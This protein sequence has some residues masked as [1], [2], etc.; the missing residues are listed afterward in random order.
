MNL[1]HDLFLL[2]F[3]LS[4]LGSEKNIIDLYIE[5][6]NDI[7]SPSKFEF[8]E[9]S[10]DDD[11]TLPLST[12][13]SFFGYIKISGNKNL[14][15]EK[16]SLIANTSFMVGSLLH[17]L[18]L[19]HTLEIKLEE[20][21][22][23]YEEK[24]IK[25]RTT[26][27]DLQNSRIAS[28]NLI[29]DLTDQID[30]R[31]EKERELRDSKEKFQTI[32]NETPVV[33]FYFNR[34]SI[35]TELNPAMEGIFGLKKSK[36]IGLNLR[37]VITDER[38][39]KVLSDTFT[40]GSGY[41]EGEYHSVISK[42]TSY[43]KAIGKGIK[44]NKGKIIAGL[45]LVEDISLK[46]RDELLLAEQQKML[47]SILEGTNAGTWDWDIISG[48]LKINDRWAD[49]MGYTVEEL[50]PVSVKT[51]RNNVH[52]EDLKKANN[53]LEEHLEG[54]TDYYNVEFRQP[55]KKGNWVWVNA[56]GKVSERDQSGKALRMSGTHI[57]ITHRKSIELELQNQNEEY[58]ALNEE[59]NANL[60]KT[61]KL[62][63]ELET[64][65]E[66]AKE[67]DRL[68]NAFL[69][70]MSHEIRTPM[71]GILGFARLLEGEN[72]SEDQLSKY[73]GIIKKSGKR[74]LTTINGII[75][76]SRIE[77]NQ[78]DINISKVNLSILMD[79]LYQFFQIESI[80]KNIELVIDLNLKKSEYQI[81]TDGDMLNAILTNL[82]KNAFK[83]TQEGK[84][85][86]G[87]SF[88]DGV[89]S[90]FVKD[91][92]IG[93]ETNRQK[94]IFDRFVQADIEDKYVYE[95]SGLGLSISKAYIEMLGGKIWVNSKKG[96]GS[97]FHFT[98]PSQK[99]LVVNEYDK[100]EIKRNYTSIKLLKEND[101][102][103]L[104]VEDEEVSDN[105]L[106]IIL[107]DYCKTILHAKNGIDAI[108][109]CKE[110]KDINLIFMDIKMPELGGYEA[111]KEIRKFNKNV[112]II[113][114]TAY[115]LSGDREKAIN[116]GCDDYIAKPIMSDNLKP[117]IDKYL[118]IK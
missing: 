98:L 111:T 91:S 68:K 44:N 112:K 96:V 29:E 30:I 104:I 26:I 43:L 13:N 36:I 33:I 94:A 72:L 18:Q 106:T 50:S 73:V 3:N 54:K 118:I 21:E 92:G 78:V 84:I 75:D 11:N 90:F 19:Q 6:L 51:W 89:F 5:G 102:K 101:M 95:G 31:K 27:E 115:A 23:L 2:T 65:L 58:E 93:I 110:H 49:I 8:L 57:D 28:M 77:S 41:F 9:E 7:F 82:V 15:E 45:G 81:I 69:A 83:Y 107:R 62:N 103:V 42:K 74:M 52:P 40:K 70:N 24:S 38:M 80:E 16:L 97:T 64:A 116:A 17:R 100:I 32:L 53:D 25:L 12:L 86:V 60:D 114:Q 61:Q 71:N 14:S 48:D 35:V 109:I 47:E 10:N 37:K 46:K 88:A 66:K 67:S 113:A 105:L 22:D 4:K 99:E 56:R 59:L 39:K 55:H 63:I 1:I 79:E 117:L 34:E 108:N 85:E 87:C 76:I 20:I